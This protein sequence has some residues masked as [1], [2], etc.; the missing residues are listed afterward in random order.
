MNIDISWKDLEDLLNYY[1]DELL[2]NKHETAGRRIDLRKGLEAHT[3][4]GYKI[5]FDM[6]MLH[7]L[8]FDE[9]SGRNYP[10]QF[11][12]AADVRYILKQANGDGAMDFKEFKTLLRY[13]EPGYFKIHKNYLEKIFAKY[14]V[15]IHDNPE[16][17]LTTEAFEALCTEKCLF[18]QVS[19]ERFFDPKAFSG[20]CLNYDELITNWEKIKNILKQNIRFFEEENLQHMHTKVNGLI[21]TIADKDPSK[22]WLNYK[23]LEQ[24]VNRMHCESYTSSLLPDELIELEQCLYKLQDDLD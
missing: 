17:V 4:T 23:L 13:A 1:L 20:L 21:N 19:Y 18:N 6:A 14:S 7:I 9:Q 10:R 12:T 15:D 24:E 5:D 22:I 2:R 8:N 3:G 11:F 16:K